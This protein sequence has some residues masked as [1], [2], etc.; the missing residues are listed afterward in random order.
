MPGRKYRSDPEALLGEGIRIVSGSADAKYQHRVEMVNLVL[1]GLTP[2]FLSEYTKDSKNAITSW[3][4]TADE[5]GFEGLRAKRQ[6]GRPRRL[7]GEQL[8][9]VEELVR[10]DGRPAWDG[11]SLSAHVRDEYG[12]GLS[13]RQCQR[14]L[15]RAAGAGGQ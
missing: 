1:A 3:V 13:V 7:S 4:K 12:V 5:E 9:E 8:A 10:R 14:I 6:D 15:R 11:R 2:Q